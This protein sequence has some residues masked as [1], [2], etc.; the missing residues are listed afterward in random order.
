MP[1]ETGRDR[2]RLERNWS[3]TAARLRRPPVADSRAARHHRYVRAAV[4]AGLIAAL[5][6]GCGGGSKSVTVTETVGTFPAQS[7][8][9]SAVS[10]ADEVRAYIAQVKSLHAKVQA[11]GCATEDALAPVNEQEPDATWDR[12]ASELSAVRD[13]FQRLAV[14]ASA[15]TPPGDLRSAH[16]AYVKAL[17]LYTT[18]LDFYADAFRDRDEATLLGPAA[19]TQKTNLSRI[20][21]SLTTWRVGVLAQLQRF[22]LDQPTWLKAVGTGSTKC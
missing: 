2:A 18:F 8:T 9:I 12:A 13:D 19:E 3:A 10:P 4:L 21:E 15:I 11:G 1:L 14:D 22:G 16:G 5:Y 7:T 20:T 6:A 17:T